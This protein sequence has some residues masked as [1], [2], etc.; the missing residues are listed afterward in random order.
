MAIMYCVVFLLLSL[1]FHGHARANSAMFSNIV[2]S[3]Q[4]FCSFRYSV[5]IPKYTGK[6]CFE[7]FLVLQMEA[8]ILLLLQINKDT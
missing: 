7:G 5:H 3:K 1:I 8:I 4:Y 6:I 2:A